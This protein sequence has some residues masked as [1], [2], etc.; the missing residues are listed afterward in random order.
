MFVSGSFITIFVGFLKGT[1]IAKHTL[2]A[3]IL[4][5]E[6][7]KSGLEKSVC[8]ITNSIASQKWDV[9]NRVFSHFTCCYT[10]YSTGVNYLDLHGQSTASMS[11]NVFSTVC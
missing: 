4:V 6:W 3:V 9:F 8:I 2:P 11:L 7:Q 10:V 5:E 1:S